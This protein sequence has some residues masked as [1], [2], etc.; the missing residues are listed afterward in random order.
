MS[1]RFPGADTI[2]QFW[3]HLVQ[4][5]DTVTRFS[6][7]EDD[8]TFYEKV[9]RDP[10][11]VRARG[12]LKDPQLFDAALFDISQADATVMDPQQRVFMELAWEALKHAG[13]N[14]SSFAGPVGVYAG[15][16]NNFYYH[17]NVST[18]P[19]LI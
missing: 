9:K 7:E 12:M 1:G 14:A 18:N 10:R 15:M 19:G 16:G 4:G 5:R 13:H 6:R 17:Y 2:E 8:P 3:D 11:Y